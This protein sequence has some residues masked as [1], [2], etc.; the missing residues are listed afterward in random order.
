MSRSRGWCFTINNFTDE[1]VAKVKSFDCRYMIYGVEKGASGTPHLQG[2]LYMSNDRTLSAMKKKFH[3]TCH[4]EVQRGTSQEAS[5]YCKKELKFT[6]RGELPRQGRR[7]DL[8][9]V[10]DEIKEGKKVDDIVMEDPYF[11]HQYGRTLHKIEDLCMRKKFRNFQTTGTWYYGTTGTGKSATAFEGYN[12]ETHYHFKYDNGWQ[13]DYAQ[14][15]TV[16]IDEFRGQ[17]PYHEMLTMVDEHPNHIM[18]R[19]SRSPLPFLSKHV[20]VTSS[21][22]P[23]EVYKNLHADDKIDQLLRRFKIVKLPPRVLLNL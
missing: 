12:P 1:D 6:E 11:Y 22:H 10:M 21:M 5:D 14:Q 23:S 4:L 18:K 20:I 19:R 17:I 13:D 7:T 16:I 8:Y 15:H 9:E 3:A 2:Y